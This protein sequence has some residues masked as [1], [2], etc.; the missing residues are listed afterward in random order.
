[1]SLENHALNYC[2]LHNLVVKDS[3]DNLQS[4]AK[5]LYKAYETAPSKSKSFMLK[6]HRNNSLLCTEGS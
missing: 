1:M 4:S 2:V 3:E 6:E 5:P